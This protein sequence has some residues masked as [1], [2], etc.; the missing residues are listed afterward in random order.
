MTR[1]GFKNALED[2]LAVPRGALRETDTRE[3]VPGWSSIVDVQILAFIA[4]QFGLEP[5][6]QLLAVESVGELLRLLEER[7]VIVN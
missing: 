1:S 2:L 5:D 6:V 7:R 4:S 3:T